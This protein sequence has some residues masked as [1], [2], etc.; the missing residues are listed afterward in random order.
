MYHNCFATTK[1]V[2]EG[3]YVVA[4]LEIEVLEEDRGTGTPRFDQ[5][6][7]VH[8]TSYFDD[9]E[10]EYCRDDVGADEDEFKKLDR[11]V[12]TLLESDDSL[13][14]EALQNAE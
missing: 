14:A 3:N 6:L 13:H 5:I 4:D 1:F 7:E 10:D 2:V 8:I 11:L 9:E 12:A